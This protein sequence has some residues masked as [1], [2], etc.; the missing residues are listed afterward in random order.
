MKT[1]WRKSQEIVLIK[2]VFVTVVVTIEMSNCIL[3]SAFQE[4]STLCA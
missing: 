2:C 4:M 3:T 1:I